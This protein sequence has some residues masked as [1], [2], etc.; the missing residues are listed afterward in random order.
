MHIIQQDFLIPHF[1]EFD[2]I[3]KKGSLF[4]NICY[5]CLANEINVIL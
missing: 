5:S 1:H 2:I 3:N 4:L